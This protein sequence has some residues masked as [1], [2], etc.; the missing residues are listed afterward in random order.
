MK[1]ALFLSFVSRRPPRR[2]FDGGSAERRRRTHYQVLGVDAEAQPFLIEAAYR[3]L[4][5]RMHP[6]KGGDT[7]QAQLI[8]EAFRVLRDPASRARYDQTL[9]PLVSGG[10]RVSLR[11]RRSASPPP[12]RRRTAWCVERLCRTG[13]AARRRGALLRASLGACPS[14]PLDGWRDACSPGSP[15]RRVEVERA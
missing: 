2:D 5:R 15:P 1:R 7:A 4:M 9:P 8:N 3:A 11:P 14:S 6:D 10:R 13:R 12:P